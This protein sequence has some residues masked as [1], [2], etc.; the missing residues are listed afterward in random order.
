M[1]SSTDPRLHN[2]LRDLH[3]FSC[4]SNIAYQTTRKLSP[5]TYNEMM[6]SLLYR[7]TNLAF[8]NDP[9]QEAIRTGLLVFCSTIY[10]QRHYMKQPYDHLL[11]LF[12]TALYN[13][14]K[15]AEE[16]FLPVPIIFWLTMLS[17][18][19]TDEEPSPTNWR[20]IWLSKTIF[21]ARIDS[22]AQAH[23]ILRSV[24]WV[25]FI[26]TQRG[27]KIFEAAIAPTTKLVVL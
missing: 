17:H 2:A 23:E 19:I 4:I 22:W 9:V 26:Q 15:S 11:N 27:K 3:A 10:M 1:E 6:I 25:D 5:E 13:L 24:A 12:I 16:K 7:L 21:R 14:H 18:I 8:R 20:S